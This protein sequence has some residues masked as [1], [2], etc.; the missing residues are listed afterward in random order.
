[1][2]VSPGRSVAAAQDVQKKN[3]PSWCAS[4]AVRTAAF[5]MA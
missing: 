1:V 2:T 3:A 4:L 5:G